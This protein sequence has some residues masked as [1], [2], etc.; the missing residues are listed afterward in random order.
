MHLLSQH[1]NNHTTALIR[2]VLT[3]MY[4]L[5]GGAFYDQSN[6]VTRGS[7]LAPVIANSYMENFEK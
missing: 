7:P 4:F 5:Y 3:T 2:Q 6:G 1:S